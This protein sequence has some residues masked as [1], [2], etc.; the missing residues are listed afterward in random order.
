MCTPPCTEVS[1]RF[2]LADTLLLKVRG[3]AIE[4]SWTKWVVWLKIQDGR[5]EPDMV[6]L[7]FFLWEIN[8]KF[9]FPAWGFWVLGM[10]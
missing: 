2:Y 4:I 1:Q 8:P 10:Q 9:F 7:T 5:Q 3:C 6:T